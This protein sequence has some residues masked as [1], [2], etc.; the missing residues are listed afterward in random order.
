MLQHPPILGS[1]IAPKIE[2]LSNR[3]QQSQSIEPCFEINAA[4]RPSP[5]IA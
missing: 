4:E 1:T 2:G 5:M 3:G